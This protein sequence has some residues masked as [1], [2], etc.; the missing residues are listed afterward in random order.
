M[1]C[2]L[3]FSTTNMQNRYLLQNNSMLVAGRYF[4]IDNNLF[5]HNI[6]LIARMA[7]FLFRERVRSC[8]DLQKKTGLSAIP[9]MK[10]GIQKLGNCDINDECMNILLSLVKNEETGRMKAIFSG[11]RE[12]GMQ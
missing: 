7:S 5:L 6:F 1:L 12:I 10:E 9:T 8:V 4:I 2:F 11:K 3:L